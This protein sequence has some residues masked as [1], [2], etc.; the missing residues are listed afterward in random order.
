SYTITVTDHNGCT[1]TTTVTV[2]PGTCNNLSVT[3]TS[4]PAVCFGN[5]NGSITAT[6][7]GGSGNFTYAWDTIA[8]TTT[9]VN[10]L[11][12]GNYTIIVTDTTTQC[13]TSTT[14]T[15]NEPNIL[16]S[17]IAVSNI[18]C[19]DDATGSLDLAVNGGTGPYTFSWNNG[20]VTE[21]LI[22]VI[23]GTYSVTITD[24]NGC[25]TSNSATIIQPDT[26]VSAS[27]TEQT[28]ILCDSLGSVT[29]LGSGGI[30][31]LTY[32]INGGTNYQTNGVFTDL[33]E[34]NYTIIVLDAN[35]CTFNQSIFITN[36][37]F[38]VVKKSTI[39]NGGTCLNAN[40]EIIY[41]FTIT[42]DGNVPIAITSINDTLLGGD[43]TA[44]V[45]LVSGD[46][47]TDGLLNPTE[48]W[49]YTAPNYTVTQDDYDAQTI[50]NTVTI[51]GTDVDATTVTA[52]DTLVIAATQFCDA[53]NN[54]T[55]VK[56]SQI[57]NGDS[58]LNAD[59]EVTY[60]FTVTNTGGNSSIA[61]TTI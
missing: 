28:N 43:I 53:S 40:S 24:A 15:I 6:V 32:S 49:I 60:T 33:T 52:T 4:T 34:G 30:E 38:N 39:A 16:S 61:I 9:S 19:K 10:N 25:A 20:S 51:N 11:P 47:N 36:S 26:N 56:S 45:T 8:D 48:T 57:T 58:C 41:T 23:A 3:G 54:F 55:V 12:A 7:T 42:N 35:G 5:S 44:D 21:D 22:N 13:T 18:L 31:P 2:N 14:I 29:V 37:C 17:A 50:S 1:D 59:S 27:I 46:T